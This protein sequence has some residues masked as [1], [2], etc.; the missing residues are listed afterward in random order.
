MAH[1]RFRKFNT[2][3][4]YPEQKLDNDLCMAV[5][6][7]NHIFLRGQVGQ[8]LQGNMVGIGDPGKQAQQAMR[9]VNQLLEEA[10]SKL[11]HVCKITV[12]ITDRAYREP[13][14]QEIG[15]WLKG[16]YPCST[17][18]IVQ[19]LARPEWVMEIDVE[20]VIPDG[21]ARREPSG[22]EWADIRLKGAKSRKRQRQTRAA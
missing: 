17:G 20:A 6:A 14:Y 15:K 19:G 3:K 5:R 2:K 13:V 7:G 9:N 4:T 1:V 16:V 12:Y 11:A 22:P 18:L 21:A 10:G 8:D